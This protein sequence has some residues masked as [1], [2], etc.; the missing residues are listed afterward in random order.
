MRHLLHIRR[1]GPS[2]GPAPLPFLLCALLWLT[3]PFIVAREK[4]TVARIADSVLG[5]K[6]GA[7]LDEAR[8]K[9]APLGTHGGRDTREGGRKEA[10]ALKETDYLHVA[11]KTN[12]RGEVVWVS[13]FVRPDREIPFSA[14]GDLSLA[15]GA[16]DAEAIWN[17]GTPGGGYRLVVKGQNGKAR[18][19]YLLSLGTPP[20]Q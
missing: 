11:F 10:Y 2:C 5:V 15:P 16:T 3:P 9:L 20:V 7:T 13:G 4:E 8:A 18:V 14:F 12:R 17:V 6:I 19:V 1:A